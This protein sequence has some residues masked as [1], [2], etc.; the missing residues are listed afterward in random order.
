MLYATPDARLLAPRRGASRSSAASGSSIRSWRRQKLASLGLRVVVAPKIELRRLE[1]AEAVPPFGSRT[2]RSTP[3]PRSE[4]AWTQSRTSSA[5]S[6]PRPARTSSMRDREHRRERGEGGAGLPRQDD[7]RRLDVE[8][9][10]DDAADLDRDRRLAEN[11]T[12]RGDEVGVG[13]DVTD[14]LDRAASAP[15]APSRPGR[16]RTRLAPPRIPAGRRARG[17]RARRRTRWR[18]RCL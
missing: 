4:L 6:E 17:D 12:R 15:H 13:A 16:A 7:V 14:D 9:A 5:T 11:P 8:Y 3:I 2:P 18:A 1:A 10:G